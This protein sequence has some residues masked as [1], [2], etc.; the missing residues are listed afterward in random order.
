MAR[1]GMEHWRRA[2][3]CTFGGFVVSLLE[4][5]SAA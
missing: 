2:V 5:S 1:T 3:V 4:G